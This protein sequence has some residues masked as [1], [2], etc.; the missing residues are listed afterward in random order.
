[1]AKRLQHR[2]PRTKRVYIRVS[3][4]DYKRLVAVSN[5]RAICPGELCFEIVV[6]SVRKQI[7]QL[8]LLGVNLDKELG[9][10]GW[11]S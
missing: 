2:E 4:I 6:N 5:Y 8:R 3:E 7:V 1:M 11:E 10:D 9:L